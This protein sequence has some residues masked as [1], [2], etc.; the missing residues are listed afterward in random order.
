MTTTESRIPARRPGPRAWGMLIIAEAKS[1][2]R[3]YAS[4]LLPLGLPLLILITSASMASSEAIGNDG[5]TAFEFYVLPIVLTMVFAYIGMLNMPTYLSH[6]RKSGI[7][8]RLGATP[9]SP[10]MVL[11]SQIVVNALLSILG[12]ALA[13]TVS[14]VFFDAVAP[15]SA[16]AVAGAFLLIMASMYGIGMIVASL[17]P[18]VNSAIA[19]GVILFLGLGALG[20]MFGGRTLLPDALQDASQYLPFGASADLLAATWTGQPVELTMIVPL[21]VA[22]VVSVVISLL[23]FR[24]E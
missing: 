15:V 17:A 18:T 24:W 7:L 5:F 16:L 9:A 2:A 21:V 14:F 22:T 8:R 1:L 3:D 11:V 23:F 10:M 12:I 19:M 6:Y 4:L 20:G 13:L